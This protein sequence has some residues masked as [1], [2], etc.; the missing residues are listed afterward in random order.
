MASLNTGKAIAQG[1]HASTMFMHDMQKRAELFKNNTKTLPSVEAFHRWCGIRGFGTVITLDI[2]DES[3]LRETIRLAKASD[4]R[5]DIV[6]DDTY[7][8][9]DGKTMHYFPVITCGYVFSPDGFK[10]V[11]LQGFKLYPRDL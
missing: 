10:P 9:Q 3:Q 11:C 8:L 1:S 2:Y 5:A 4:L 7:P 6:V